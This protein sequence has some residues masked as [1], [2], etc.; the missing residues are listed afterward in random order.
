MDI[1]REE[2]EALIMKARVKAGWIDEA[3]LAAPA[4]AEDAE[5][6]AAD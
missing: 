2:A 1:S 5:A 3:A 6:P 4:E